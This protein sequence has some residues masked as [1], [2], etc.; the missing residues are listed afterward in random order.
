MINVRKTLLYIK[1]P[2]FQKTSKCLKWADWVEM[3]WFQHAY[4]VLKIVCYLMLKSLASVSVL[5]SNSFK[6]PEKCF[7]P[8]HN[9]NRKSTKTG[10]FL[11]R[12]LVILL[13]GVRIETRRREREHENKWGKVTFT[14]LQ[15]WIDSKVRRRP[16]IG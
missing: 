2:V 4:T 13:N 12:T 15:L 1:L 7:S 11:E 5:S 6:K 10:S 16:A 14:T 9:R 3:A 8:I